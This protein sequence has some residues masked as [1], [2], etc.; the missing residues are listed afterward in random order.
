MVSGRKPDV[1]RRRQAAFLRSAGLTLQQIADRL[2]VTRQ[3]VH[4][5]LRPTP[6]AQSFKLLCAVC[7]KPLDTGG[8]VSRDAG[9]AL[10]LDC[11]AR[12]LDAPFWQRLKSLRLAAGLTRVELER[13][14]GL[15]RGKVAEYEDRGTAPR[16]A[17]FAKLAG[18][19]QELGG[20][21]GPVPLPRNAGRRLA[22]QAERE[23]GL[24]RPRGRPR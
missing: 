9:R 1:E 20:K 21:L 3:C 11:L 12:A 23:P 10:C 14:A 2:G 15:T 13:R 18:A 7:G 6:R 24:R 19:L 17:N 16:P 22:A 5:L 4:L 8:A